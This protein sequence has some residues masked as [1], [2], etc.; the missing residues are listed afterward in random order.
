MPT[1]TLTIATKWKAI[2]QPGIP[3]TDVEASSV[4]NSPPMMD[5][6]FD[7]NCSHPKAVPRLLSSV[8]SA[9]S[10][11]IAGITMASPIPF[12]PLATAT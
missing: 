12:K 5:P 10:D 3:M 2:L 1:T 7:V 6:K 11:C 4:A 9:T 8:E